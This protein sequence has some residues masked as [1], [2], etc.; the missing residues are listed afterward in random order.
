MTPQKSNSIWGVPLLMS[1]AEQSTGSRLHNSVPIE[2]QIHTFLTRQIEAFKPD[3][4]IAVERKG[5]AIIRA[6]N[7]WDEDPLKWSWEKVISSSAVD[8][9]SNNYFLGKRILVFDDMMNTGLHLNRLLTKLRDRGL[10]NPEDRNLRIAIFAVHA[11]SSSRILF[12][13][14]KVPHA[15]FYRD[16][17]SANYQLI[18]M[19][20]VGMLQKAGSLMLDTEH[21]EVRVRLH[22]NLNQFVKALGRKAK[23]I[24]FRSLDERTNITVFYE[25]TRRFPHDRFPKNTDFSNIVMK[26]RVIQRDHFGDEFALIPI[27]YPSIPFP[28]T[29]WLDNQDLLELLGDGVKA[30]EKA[31]FY[32]AGLLAGLE[33]LKWVLRDLSIWGADKYALSFPKNPKESDSKSGYALNHLKVMFPTL[34]VER[35]TQLIYK[36]GKEAESEGNVLKKIKFESCKLPLSSDEELYQKAINLLQVIQHVLDQR[37]M[38]EYILKDKGPPHPYGLTAK[39]IFHLG[40][41]EDL[42]LQDVQISTL[43]DILIDGAYIIP[44]VE[45]RTDESGC[46]RWFRT[47][48]PDGEVVS[49]WVRRYTTQWGLP[50]GF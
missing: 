35:L 23:V 14:E 9:V 3:L 16:L 49:D 44:H 42:N 13:D 2:R 32:G 22:S 18:R 45:R 1:I 24:V 40:K 28:S 6:L 7:D 25:N 43:F 38:E 34:D 5:T 15:W 20:I 47:F 39:E 10:W 11:N 33:V 17:T 48:Q 46:E 19:L 27:C 26:C 21:I 31:R 36:I 8:Q 37:V 12:Q 29:E 50:Y 41:M 30:S 4:I